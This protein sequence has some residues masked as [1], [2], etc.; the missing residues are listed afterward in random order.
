MKYTFP[1][2]V[3]SGSG[4]FIAAKGSKPL[5]FSRLPG[6][7]RTKPV[8]CG[9]VVLFHIPFDW[10]QRKT[11]RH[12]GVRVSG[13]VWKTSQHSPTASP[14]LGEA[15]PPVATLVGTVHLSHTVRVSKGAN[16]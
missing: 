10:S 11:L 3:V 9:S 8:V 14:C 6:V 2:E 7:P 16:I 1:P 15:S 4:V 5:K 13:T 12:C